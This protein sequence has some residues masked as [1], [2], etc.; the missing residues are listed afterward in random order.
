MPQSPPYKRKPRVPSLEDPGPFGSKRG[1][2]IAICARGKALISVSVSLKA[3]W[4][5]Y[6]TICYDGGAVPEI[7]AAAVFERKTLREYE[8]AKTNPLQTS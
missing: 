7:G 6:G 1:H 3:D 2:R 5:H 8:N 4:L